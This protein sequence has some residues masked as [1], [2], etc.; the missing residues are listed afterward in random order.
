MSKLYHLILLT[1]GLVIM[2]DIQAV[3]D[4]SEYK[5]PYYTVQI[6][7]AGTGAEFRLNDIPFYL[8]IRE[9]QV[10]TEI[11]VSDKLIQGVNELSIITF[12]YIEGNGPV[13][14]WHPDARVEASLYVK[15]KDAPR[16][17]RK[18]L[19]HIKLYPAR[20]PEIA[21]AESLVLSEQEPP[22]LDYESKPWQFPPT[23]YPKQVVISRKTHPVKTP[24]PH[25]EWQDGQTIE[26]TPENYASLLEAYR[27]YH[28]IHQKQNLAALKA[29]YQKIA[30]IQKIVNYY[31]DI[32][33][34]YDI[35][36]LK[37]SWISDQQ[38]LFEFIEGERSKK[39]G[40]KLDIIANGKM[41]RIVN[42]TGIQ[43]ILYIVK[44]ERIT[45]EYNFTFYKNKNGEWI[46]IM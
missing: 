12:P 45:I 36:N 18:L 28:A 2:T 26:D 38:E 5:K 19:S 42:N 33:K 41:A 44:K 24:F 20:D 4:T 37:E 22:I 3:T 27:K 43:P 30:R 35:L 40:L 6:S 1:L 39:F 8:E 17:T 10:D 34:A 9:G 29:G 13:E 46:H 11:P 15:E 25:W 23:D 21:A 14:N 16:Q 31:D 32:D 7:Y